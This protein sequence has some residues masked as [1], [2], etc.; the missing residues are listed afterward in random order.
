MKALVTG[1]PGFLGGHLVSRL[2]RRGDHVKALARATSDVERL[3]TDGVEIVYGDLKDIDSL[4]RAVEGVDIVYHAGA[5]TSGTWEEYEESTVRGTERMLQ[6]SLEAGVERFIH[7]SSVSAY[8]T[9]SLE[10]NGLVDESCLIEEAPE[11]VGP[12]AHSKVEAEKLAFRYFERGL[13]VVVI[14]PGLLFGPRGRVM[15]PNLGY[16][17][18][19]GL[20]VVMGSGDDLLPLTYIENAVDGIM[21]AGASERAVGQAYHITEASGMTKRD[22]LKRYMAATHSSFLTITLPMPLMLIP[23]TLAGILKSLGVPKMS[24]IPS[25]YGVVSKFKSLQFDASKARTELAW[26]PKISLEEGLKRTFDW[27]NDSQA[28]R[29][30]LEATG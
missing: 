15:W 23:L 22:Y 14:R 19:S 30:A 12:Y 20:Y 6:L 10:R 26:H 7:I 13:P 29:R 8:Q 28:R 24:S 4:R 9:Y 3:L 21:L 27:Y 2:A 1:A 25:R 17:V 18:R 16:F 5:A 11:R